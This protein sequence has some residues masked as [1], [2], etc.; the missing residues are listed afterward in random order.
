MV[1]WQVTTPNHPTVLYSEDDEPRQT[2][3]RN[4]LLCEA[5]PDELTTEESQDGPTAVLRMGFRVCGFIGGLGLIQ[6]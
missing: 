2:Q 1:S 5:R 6:G 3:N 4:T